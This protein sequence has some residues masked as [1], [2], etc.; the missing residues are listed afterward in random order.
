MQITGVDDYLMLLNGRRNA[1]GCLLPIT[2]PHSDASC[3]VDARTGLTVPEY[4][5]TGNAVV[6]GFSPNTGSRRELGI[7][8]KV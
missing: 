4:A 6:D 1:E 2:R 8:E 5:P 7:D 3:G